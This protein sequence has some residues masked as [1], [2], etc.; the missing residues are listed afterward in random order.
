MKKN[1]ASKRPP[2]GWNSYDQYD[3]T[4]TEA[5]IRASADAM[6]NQLKPFGWEYIVV[7]IQWYSALAGTRRKQWQYIPF[8]ELPMDEF[9]RL[10][11]AVSR[12]PS[13]ANGAG[14]APLAAYVHEK[15]LKF[16]IHIMRGIPRQAVHQ[17]LPILGSEQTADLVA[18]PSPVCPWNPDMYGLMPNQPG[19]QAWYDSVFALYAQWGVDF[20]K[21]DDICNIK[22]ECPYGAKA[23]IE[24]IRKAIDTCGRDM[25]L[26]LSPGPALIEEAWHLS[27]NANLWRIT[28]DFWDEWSLLRNMFDRCE[29]WQRHVVEGCWPDCDMLPLGR[30]GR[31]FGEERDTRFTRDEQRTMMHLWCIFRS[32]LML[33]ADM[34]QLDPWT[35]SLLTNRDLMR[36]Q[37]YAMQPVQV[38]RDT[39]SVVW[40]SR[41]EV[42]GRMNVAL[43][44]LSDETREVQVDLTR[45]MMLGLSELR[46][47]WADEPVSE[48]ITAAAPLC[49]VTLRSHASA[50][51]VLGGSGAVGC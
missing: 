25:V 13:S 20:V 51:F 27:Q 3:T 40:M 37:Q 12:F 9:G 50:F 36:A 11:P 34:S 35:L 5:E 39:H 19:S 30:I 2:M 31:G 38:A 26:S 48:S 41:D 28:D 15:G 14:F 29:L 18:L 42:D 49:S 7:D 47:V 17:H 10:Q 32:P 46:N 6:A 4:V 24:M 44:N 45:A 23:E 22:G 1:N 21:V 16:G 33:G 8:E 43:F